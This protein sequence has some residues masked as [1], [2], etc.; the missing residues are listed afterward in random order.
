MA[1]DVDALCVVPSFAF[2]FL[3]LIGFASLCYYLLF[4]FYDKCYL[5]QCLGFPTV[6]YVRPARP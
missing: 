1:L 4:A 3:L 2:C 5:S 6:W